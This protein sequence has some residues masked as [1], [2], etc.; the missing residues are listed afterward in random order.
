L[1]FMSRALS[2]S[3]NNSHVKICKTHKPNHP[4]PITYTKSTKQ[5][6]SRLNP[7]SKPTVQI[8]G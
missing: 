8:A 4:A 5:I 2:I 1:F 7:S 6:A 3:L